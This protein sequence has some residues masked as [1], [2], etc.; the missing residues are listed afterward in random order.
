M[1]QLGAHGARTAVTISLIV[2]LLVALG[3]AIY[4]S[5]V[6]GVDI[7]DAFAYQVAVVAAER[8][9]DILEAAAF[10]RHVSPANLRPYEKLLDSDLDRIDAIA[11]SPAER[12]P[13][14][15]LPADRP[16]YDRLIVELGGRAALGRK[17]FE[18]TVAHNTKARYATNALFALVALIFAFVVGR[19]REQ[20]AQG[21]SLV[22]GLQ[23]AFISRRRKLPGVDF[24]S[25]L[26]SA[27]RGS[28]VGGDTH[29]AFTYDGQSGLFLVADVSGKG[30]DA[31][32]DTALIKY[33]I[34]T[35]F[36]EDSDPGHV[37]G[38]FA[39]IYAKTVE[40]PESFVVLFLGTIA[41]ADGTVRYA[42]AGHEPAWVRHGTAVA[43]LPPT[44]PIVG[45]DPQP[46]YET[47]QLTL[48]PGDALV[49][50]TDG[51]TEARD[52]RGRMLGVDG[53]A[54]WISDLPLGAQATADAIV[55]RLRKRS[56]RIA[57]DLAIVVIRYAP[58]TSAPGGSAES[59]PSPALAAGPGS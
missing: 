10:D 32:V 9:V 22:Q 39:K 23:R 26:L 33:T 40:S 25:V 8:D 52:R 13:R 44:G 36:H 15:T 28:N 56:Q 53:V 20:L 37:L 49:V 7:N 58:P 16:E 31:A 41:F 4:L 1:G 35:L 21:R 6:G 34:R 48:A 42:S 55:R 38:A 45:I 54:R 29:D 5:Y 2:V 3:F 57:D 59:I 19:L 24:G 47:G 11:L 27:T 46:V 50:S 17:R 14:M 12:A 43:V 18:D 30:I 51:L